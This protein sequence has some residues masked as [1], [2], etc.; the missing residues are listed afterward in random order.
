MYVSGRKERFIFH[1]VYRNEQGVFLLQ[2]NAAQVFQRYGIQKSLPE[3]L[4][5]GG[6]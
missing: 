4:T 1:A 5:E 2:A 3:E 6:D